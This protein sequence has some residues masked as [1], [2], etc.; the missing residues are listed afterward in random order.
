M[1]GFQVCRERSW[2]IRTNIWVGQN[3]SWPSIRN[4]FHQWHTSCVIIILTSNWMLRWLKIAE[5]RLQCTSY[6]ISTNLLPLTVTMTIPQ[7]WMLDLS[8]ISN[9]TRIYLTS[10][11]ALY[12][13]YT[14]N[15]NPFFFSLKK[16][17]V[18]KREPNHVNQPNNHVNHRDYFFTFNNN[19]FLVL[20]TKQ[21]GWKDFYISCMVTYCLSCTC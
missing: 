15:L 7:P 21:S 8:K 5:Y 19:I 9:L 20:K 2:W 6:Q 12:H 4:L 1:N 11:M 17:L 10:N 16:D 13:R 14:V 3:E 18:P